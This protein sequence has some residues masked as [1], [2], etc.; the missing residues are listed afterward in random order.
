MLVELRHDGLQD[1]LVGHA[2]DEVRVGPGEALDRRLVALVLRAHLTRLREREERGAVVTR[3]RADAVGDLLEAQPGRQR[4]HGVVAARRRARRRAAEH[5]GRGLRAHV[6]VQVVG[7]GLRRPAGRPGT[8]AGT[9]ATTRRH[10]CSRARR[11]SPSR[12]TPAA[13]SRYGRRRRPPARTP[14]RRTTPPRPGTAARVPRAHRAPPNGVGDD[15]AA[16]RDGPR[17]APACSGLLRRLLPRPES[18]SER[19]VIL[20]RRFV[21]R[22]VPTLPRTEPGTSPGESSAHWASSHDCR[23]TAAAEASMRSRWAR[24]RL[25]R[26]GVASRRLRWA[27]IV[28]K[29]SS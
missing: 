17:R 16:R 28:E 19:F 5:V 27:I 14:A 21:R 7:P 13:R 9:R 1:L 15:G 10:L 22:I 20:P 26:R 2:L 4:E 12:P 8:R 29:R 24:C 18:S 6:L 25:L 3:E 23:I 11:R